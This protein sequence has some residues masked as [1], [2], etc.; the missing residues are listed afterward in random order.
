MREL[1][2][3]YCR[4]AYSAVL[5]L[6]AGDDLAGSVFDELLGKDP[7]SYHAHAGY[8]LYSA[9]GV[10]AAL[11]GNHDFDMDPLI[12]IVQAGKLGRFLGEVSIT[13]CDNHAAVT[14]ARLTPT[15]D[16]DVD[17]DFEQGNVQPL[18]AQAHR[19]LS[20]SLGRVASHSDPSTE[21]VRNEFVGGE[22]ALVNFISDA[23]VVRCRSCDYQVDFAMVDS[24]SLRIG[25]PVG[26]ELAFGEWFELMPFADN[27]RL[28]RIT[29]H[30]LKALLADNALRADRPGEPQ[31]ERGFVHFSQ[32]LRY[33][34]RMGSRRGDA[35]ATDV[36]VDGFPWMINWIALSWP[37]ATASFAKQLPLGGAH[38]PGTPT[39]PP[40]R[41]RAAQL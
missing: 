22:L 3:R 13:L 26:G 31:I 9:G 32:Q 16:L 18:V 8:Q 27:V 4:D 36:T 19:F 7:E 15:I 37:P 33:T 14:N 5:V 39:S 20:R 30:Q 41:T 35:R 40:Q 6:S 10:D 23:L 24:S 29:G 2:H 1:R 34:L 21:A 11:L 25:L 17:E 12:P 28:C 38:H